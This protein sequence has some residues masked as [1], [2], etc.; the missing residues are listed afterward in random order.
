MTYAGQTKWYLNRRGAISGPHTLPELYRLIETDEADLQDIAQAEG[1]EGWMPL[2]EVIRRANAA[3]PAPDTF[4]GFSPQKAGEKSQPS[5]PPTPAVR[6]S[7][8]L[9]RHWRGELSLAVSYWVNSFVVSLALSAAIG[10]LSTTDTLQSGSPRFAVAWL[11]GA[12]LVCLAVGLWQLVGTWRS[13]D[14]HTSRGGRRFWSVAVKVLLCL[15]LIRGVTELGMAGMTAMNAWRHVATMEELPPPEFLLLRGGTEVEFRGGIRPGTA[16][17][18]REILGRAPQARIIHLGSPGGDLTEGHTMAALVRARGMDTYVRS[19]CLSACASVF[20]AGRNR[21]LK[22]GALLGFHAP[23]PVA[24]GIEGVRIVEAERRAMV[25]SGLPEWFVT[26]AFMARGSEMWFPTVDELSTARVVTFVT[27]GRH[28]SPGRPAS[29]KNQ[30]EVENTLRAGVL[31]AALET[32]NAGAFRDLASRLRAVHNDGGTVNDGIAAVERAV[33]PF[34][35]ESLK[36]LPDRQIVAA[37]R[38]IV[39]TA[40]ALGARDS[41]VCRDWLMRRPGEPLPDVAA[42]LTQQQQQAFTQ[43]MADVIVAAADPRQGAV[44][45]QRE[46][47][48]LQ[49]VIR[50]LDARLPRG[51][52]AFFNAPEGT[53]LPPAAVCTAVIELYMEILRLPEREAGPVLR[54]LLASV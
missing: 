44:P 26:R 52:M 18:L 48:Q 28:L 27:D 5:V 17:Q 36:K 16:A 37:I 6:R 32:A 14:R 3:A 40:R 21:L 34:F 38:I 53:Q 19:S 43:A 45:P 42:L 25:T 1:V 10:A 4:P 51:Q 13:A 12:F 41:R 9:L 54:F 46:P 24:S 2:S 49:G 39:D 8:Y 47:P 35:A 22:E 20:L 11:T 30:A 23:T 7:N 50:R 31:G 29:L 33:A 15:G